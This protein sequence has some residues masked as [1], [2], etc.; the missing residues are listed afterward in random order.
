MGAAKSRQGHRQ[1]PMPRSLC[2]LAR[3]IGA[4]LLAAASTAQGGNYRGHVAPSALPVF[5]SNG[6]CLGLQV[7]LPPMP[8]GAATSWQQWPDPQAHEFWWEWNR[9]ALLAPPSTVE[10]RSVQNANDGGP[11]DHSDRRR[12]ARS[13]RPRRAEIA[14][15]VVPTL[16][17]TLEAAR[18]RPEQRDLVR[19]CLVALA[20]ID[21]LPADVSLLP[22][23]AAHLRSDD[24]LVR[25]TAAVALG[26]AAIPGDEAR[27]LLI[28]LALDSAN[29]Q[30]ACGGPVDDRT[31]VFALYGLGLVG[32]RSQQLAT[33]QLVFATLRTVLANDPLPSPDLHVGALQACGQLAI[34]TTTADGEAL[35]ADCLALLHHEFTEPRDIRAMSLRAHVPTAVARLLDGAHPQAAGWKQRFTDELAH[36]D[37]T[38]HTRDRITESCA[39]ALGAMSRSR[40]VSDGPSGHDHDDDHGALLRRVAMAH[41]NQQT[42]FFALLSLGRLGGAE[43]QQAI[44]QVLDHGTYREKP[45]AV[46]ALGLSL[47][48]EVRA[49]HPTDESSDLVRRRLH[50]ELGRARDPSLIGALGLALGLANANEAADDLRSLLQK[51]V[52]KEEMAGYLAIGLARMDDA[53]TRTLLGPLLVETHRRQTLLQFGATALG[54]RGDQNAAELLLRL[55]RDHDGNS[56]NAQAALACAIGRTG[57][58]RSIH[59]LRLL[60]RDEARSVRIRAAAAAALGMLADEDAMPWN[61]GYAAGTN[62]RAAP[63]TLHDGENGIVDLL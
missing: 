3:G 57:D 41:S 48:D 15:E 6:T 22:I 44:L 52:A 53:A 40:R 59:P 24:E 31:R 9:E 50:Q 47:R 56:L 2:G 18:R 13:I 19:A 29:G 37:G 12:G 45:W 23:F 54:H 30:T 8:P 35:L 49:D 32:G 39:L 51:S 4:L 28:A 38:D 26:I 20:R 7:G 5:R 11:A 60:M 10:E 46:L 63:P 21:E 16:L 34:P 36:F 17:G 58:R 61:V 25:A 62:Y 1:S 42:R 55:L 33:K 14:H 27:D 43:H